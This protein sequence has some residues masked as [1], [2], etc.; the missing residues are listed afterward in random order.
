MVALGSAGLLVWVR[1]NPIK[2]DALV[3]P[4]GS[5]LMSGVT[6]VLGGSGRGLQVPGV[7][8]GWEI[9]HRCPGP[10]HHPFPAPRLARDSLS[11]SRSPSG[12]SGPMSFSAL[13]PFW[14]TPALP[15]NVRDTHLFLC[16][17]HRGARN[18]LWGLVVFRTPKLPHG[19]GGGAQ[20]HVPQV[21]TSQKL[22]P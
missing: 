9:W 14:D 22:I 19:L 7:M 8:S 1:C 6:R 20:S 17:V 4:A 11:P 13:V 21:S 3:H 2:R 10:P 15:R 12:T 16:W 5:A 18:G